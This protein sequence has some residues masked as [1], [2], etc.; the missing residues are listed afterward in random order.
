MAV[1]R[2]GS[3]ALLVLAMSAPSVAWGQSTCSAGQQYCPSGSYAGTCQVNTRSCPTGSVSATVDGCSACACPGGQVVCSNACV[4]TQAG[5]A[6]TT[7]TG[8]SGTYN[9]CGTSC[10][11]TPPESVI[12]T[13]SAAQATIPARS[14]RPGIF[15]NQTGTGS[16]VQLQQSGANVLTVNGTGLQIGLQD[17]GLGIALGAGDAG[18]NLLYGVVDY[19]A[20]NAGDALLLLQTAANSG[21]SQVPTTRFRVDREGNVAASGGAT[22]AGGITAGSGSVGIIDSTG[23]IP[24]LS[25]TYLAN[26]SGANLT[27]LNAANLTGDSG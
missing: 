1:T 15:L 6:C 23:K 16:I 9:A 25:S 14:S 4:A 10:T 19:A 13:P 17:G 18:Q 3:V 27:S 26:L 22:I 12:I 7:A 24:E 8:D 20:S 11:A 5:N 2:I 21:G